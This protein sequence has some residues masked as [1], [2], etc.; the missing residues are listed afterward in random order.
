MCSRLNDCIDSVPL[1]MSQQEQTGPN[2]PA[3]RAEPSTTVLAL[4]D[5][6]AMLDWTEADSKVEKAKQS[7]DKLLRQ[8]LGQC[9]K[10]KEKKAT[11]DDLY[12]QLNLG[13]QEVYFVLEPACLYTCV[14]VIHVCVTWSSH[15]MTIAKFILY[16]FSSC[17]FIRKDLHTHLGEQRNLCDRLLQW[18]EIDGE[19]PTQSQVAAFLSNRAE[20][21]E[22]A[23]E[24]LSGFAA[25]L[26]ARG[27]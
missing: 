1:G 12:N 17:N 24:K 11:K 25:Q 20:E 26:R 3:S 8:C 2:P 5:G 16:G 15:R 14:D 10:L 23:L 27:W 6:K 21:A 7:F 13:L 19:E 9:Q 22:K 4:T 18:H